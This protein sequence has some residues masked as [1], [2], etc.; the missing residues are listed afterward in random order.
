[1]T[2]WQFWLLLASVWIVGIA[3]RDEIRRQGDRIVNAIRPPY[4]PY[5]DPPAEPAEFLKTGRTSRP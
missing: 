5:N 4:I 3:I 1:M 2:D